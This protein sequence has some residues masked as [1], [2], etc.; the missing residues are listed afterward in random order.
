MLEINHLKKSFGNRC[1]YE[2]ISCIF[3][4]GKTYTLTGKSG[5]GKSTLL[6]MIAKLEPY[7]AGEILYNNQDIKK[8]KSSNYYRNHLG[9]LFQ[10]YGLIENESIANNL[11]L[12]LIGKKVNKKDKQK[13]FAEVMKQ[14]DL[15]YMDLNQKV[16][17]ISGGEYQRVAIA[18]IILKNPDIILADEPTA[19]LDPNTAETIMRLFLSLKNENNIILIATHNL[20]FCKLTDETL[21]IKDG[22]LFQHSLD[23]SNDKN[24]KNDN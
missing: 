7:D 13:L 3:E 14:V 15:S 17:E 1:I 12:G 19:S 4:N 5:S 24:N 8:I 2:N 20:D 11:E 21:H 10:N 6:N 23:E 18:K 9:Y 22:R 16:Y